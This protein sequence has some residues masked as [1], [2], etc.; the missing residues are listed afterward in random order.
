MKIIVSPYIFIEKKDM[1]QLTTL[2][3]SDLNRIVE[4]VVRGVLCEQRG[5]MAVLESH[6]NYTMRMVS[7]ESILG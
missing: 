7:M 4:G 2:T 3:R 6:W 5:I 1:K